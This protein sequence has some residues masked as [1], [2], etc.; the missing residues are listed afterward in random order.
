MRYKTCKVVDLIP[1]D[2]CDVTFDGKVVGRA[3]VIGDDISIAVDDDNLRSLITPRNISF[4]IG[5]AKNEEV[6]GS[7]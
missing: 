2:G 6:Q 1:Q 3:I 4:S 7:R 5:G